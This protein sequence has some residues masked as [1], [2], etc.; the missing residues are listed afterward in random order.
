MMEPS[1]CAVPLNGADPGDVALVVGE[2]EEVGRV[3]VLFRAQCPPQ[4]LPA[5]HQTAS[6]SAT[7]L[8]KEID[9]SL[10]RAIEP[11]SCRRAWNNNRQQWIFVALPLQRGAKPLRRVELRHRLPTHIDARVVEIALLFPHR[12]SEPTSLL[13]GLSRAVLACSLITDRTFLR[14]DAVFCAGKF[15]LRQRLFIHVAPWRLLGRPVQARCGAM[16]LWRGIGRPA[17]RRT[18]GLL[19]H[20]TIRHLG[21]DCLGLVVERH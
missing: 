16:L 19:L 5:S 14:F 11:T 12:K 10:A 8:R 21:V 1:I 7:A 18:W 13:F 3:V 20:D 9:P 4:P 2:C 6:M 17:L 15:P